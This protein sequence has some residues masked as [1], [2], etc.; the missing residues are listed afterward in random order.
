MDRY[1]I[2]SSKRM[3]LMK[4]RSTIKCTFIINH[5][6]RIRVCVY[7]CINMYTITIFIY[8]III[9]FIDIFVCTAHVQPA[10]FVWQTSIR[11]GSRVSEEPCLGVKNCLKKISVSSWIMM[12]A[13][14][15]WFVVKEL[16][17][18]FM[19]NDDS[20]YQEVLWYDWYHREG[21]WSL[22]CHG[23]LYA[24][25]VCPIIFINFPE[26]CDLDWGSTQNNK[27]KVKK[28]H[29]IQ[30]WLM[31]K[32]NLYIECTQDPL[33]WTSSLWILVLCTRGDDFLEC[34]RI[35]SIYA[36]SK[37]EKKTRA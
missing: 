8:Y 26:F 14:F 30:N 25:Q 20:R 21:P 18:L 31:C 29:S 9:V 22:D 11:Y 32:A 19:V 33:Q 36:Q 15:W 23:G 27:L 1:D 13:L 6:H 35:L 17:N 12:K 24:T 34:M 10:P 3:I 16:T 7:R 37:S 4:T 5:H 28:H 2:F